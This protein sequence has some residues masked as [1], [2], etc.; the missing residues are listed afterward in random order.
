MDCCLPEM[1]FRKSLL[2][3]GSGRKPI[4]TWEVGLAPGIPLGCITAYVEICPLRLGFYSVKS[5]GRCRWV[6]VLKTL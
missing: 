4:T 3:I 6:H 1:G 2:A 5:H